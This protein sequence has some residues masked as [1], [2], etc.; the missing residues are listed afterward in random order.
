M[1]SFP[2]THLQ[3]STGPAFWISPIRFAKKCLIAVAILLDSPQYRRAIDKMDPLINLDVT[4]PFKVGL[5]AGCKH[6]PAQLIFND[7][8][9]L[10]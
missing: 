10:I 7:V 6:S 1:F 4:V 8:T 9:F 2:S 3:L 5:Q